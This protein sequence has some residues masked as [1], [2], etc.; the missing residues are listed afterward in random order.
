MTPLA[1]VEATTLSLAG[2]AVA[3]LIILSIPRRNR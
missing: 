1:V 2:L 3:V